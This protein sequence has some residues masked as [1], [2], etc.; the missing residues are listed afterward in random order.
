MSENIS[1]RSAVETILIYSVVLFIATVLFYFVFPKYEIMGPYDVAGRV[2]IP[3]FY[4]CNI[5]TG[6]LQEY[7]VEGKIWTDV[8]RNLIR[9]LD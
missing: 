8:E 1:K 7:N 3:M 2:N 9:T 5:I 4:R 6:N